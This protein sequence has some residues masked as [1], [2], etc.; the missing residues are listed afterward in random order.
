MLQMGYKGAETWVPWALAMARRG[1]GCS[2]PLSLLPL[3][4]GSLSVH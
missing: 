4:T 1:L 3:I 2:E